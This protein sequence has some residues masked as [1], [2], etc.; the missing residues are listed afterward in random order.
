MG[1]M[2]DS[3]GNDD[4]ENFGVNG[5]GAGGGGGGGS[6]GASMAEW[7]NMWDDDTEDEDQ[8]QLQWCHSHLRRLRRTWTHRYW[9]ATGSTRRR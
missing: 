6:E 5:G 9:R 8:G 2:A 1:G 3:G 7:L 4:D